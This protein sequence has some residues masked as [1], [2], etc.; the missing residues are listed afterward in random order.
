MMISLNILFKINQNKDK[1]KIL[2]NP[3]SHL[4]DQSKETILIANCP[5][6]E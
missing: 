4:N 3:V 1:T 5:F 2:S 6:I